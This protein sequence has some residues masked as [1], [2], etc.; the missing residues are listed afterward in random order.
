MQQPKNVKGVW[1]ITA[2]IQTGQQVKV[3]YGF[4]RSWTVVVRTTCHA[5]G[6]EDL[7]RL[8]ESG[9]H[10]DTFILEFGSID[11]AAKFASFADRNLTEQMGL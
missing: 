5:L 1:E 10:E 6:I 9:E 4:A 3:I 7:P 11:D 8:V 2:V